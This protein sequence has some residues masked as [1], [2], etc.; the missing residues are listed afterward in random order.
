[1]N[2]LLGD[3]I[4]VCP[5]LEPNARSRYVYL[6]KGK[7][8]HYW[9][10]NLYEGGKEMLAEAVLEE[11]PL[12]IREGAVLPFNP[13]MQYVGQK[14]VD[15]LT[16]KSYFGGEGV[17]SYLYEDSGDG[18]DYEKGFTTLKNLQQFLL[19]VHLR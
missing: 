17:I 12:Y 5:V 15:I 19:L 14:P 13:V 8:Y 10:N 7:W 2:S 11:I 18:Y 16:L 4:L 6:P 9:S 3:H 1:M